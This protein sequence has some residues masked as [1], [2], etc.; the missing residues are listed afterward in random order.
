MKRSVPLLISMSIALVFVL[1]HLTIEVNYFSQGVLSQQG[2]IRALD[3]KALDHKFATRSGFELPP[4]EIVIAAIDEKSLDRHGL[5]PWNRTVVADFI[6]QAT[7]GG[8]AFGDRRPILKR[9]G[10]PMQRSVT[11]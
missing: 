7:R 9:L 2:F 5:W 6:T 11:A 10:V 3:R 1:V 4:P 8:A